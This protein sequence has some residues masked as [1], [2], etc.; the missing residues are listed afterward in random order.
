MSISEAMATLDLTTQV[1]E[2]VGPATWAALQAECAWRNGRRWLFTAVPVAERFRVTR[3][4]AEV[5]LPR[6]K[7]E[8][9]LL[10]FAG[11]DQAIQWGFAQ[12]VFLDEEHA[13]SAYATVR[14][15]SR[16]DSAAAMWRQWVAYVEERNQN[17]QSM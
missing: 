14:A 1:G 2:T 12:G 13:R 16:P 5:E 11:P 15:D 8:A 17:S 10:S 9:P 4:C 3:L 7:V 6:P